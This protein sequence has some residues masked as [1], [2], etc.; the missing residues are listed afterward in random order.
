MSKN[1]SSPQMQEPNRTSL[2][3]NNFLL[4]KRI[5][6]TGA[7]GTIGSE[8]TRQLLEEYQVKEVVCID[9]NE[10]DLFFLEQKHLAHNNV[11]FALADIDRKSVV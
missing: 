8:L 6:V 3:M 9:N 2:N 11:H 7:C 10:S 4:T 5:L 1:E